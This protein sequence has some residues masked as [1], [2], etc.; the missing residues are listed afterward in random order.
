MK[1]KPKISI[2]AVTNQ[3]RDIVLGAPYPLVAFGQMRNCIVLDK[4]TF[5]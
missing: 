5:L 1:Y 2:K 3:N 4:Q